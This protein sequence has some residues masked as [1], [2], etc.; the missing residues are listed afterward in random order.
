MGFNLAPPHVFS[1]KAG[2]LSAGFCL[3][4]VKHLLDGFSAFFSFVAGPALG[5]NPN[6]PADVL[7]C[8]DE[9]LNQQSP[10]GPVHFKQG[11]RADPNQQTA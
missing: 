10:L 5:R 1:T 4:N 6:S 3:P 9:V 11:S 2:F 8:S 7:S